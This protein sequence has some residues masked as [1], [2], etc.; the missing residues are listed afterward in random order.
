MNTDIEP[1]GAGKKQA[2]RVGGTVQKR[3]LYGFMLQG[4]E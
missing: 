4:T 1:T 2:K 3:L